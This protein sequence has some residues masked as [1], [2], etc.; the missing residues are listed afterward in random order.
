MARDESLRGRPRATATRRRALRAAAGAAAALI[1][2]PSTGRAATQ[3]PPKQCREDAQ[4]ILDT[5]LLA[6]RI[7]I[8]FYYTGLTTRAVV[9]DASTSPPSPGR[10][11]ARNTVY[12]QSILAEERE[13]TRLLHSAG[14]RTTAAS[15]YFPAATFTRLGYTSRSGLFLQ[16]FDLIETVLVGA[17]LAAIDNL[18]I[19][20]RTDLAVLAIRILEA[21]CKHRALGRALARDDPADNITLEVEPFACV[22]DA[23]TAL[24]PFL[25]GQGF[26]GGS[27]PPIPLPTRD[28]VARV[29]QSPPKRR[30]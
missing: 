13:H 1:A 18:G 21:E 28:Q 16:V 11:S 23:A 24:R 29:L 15:F 25:T 7:A 9:D 4:Q 10:N 26:R 12:L 3:P 19:L 27:T 17:Y 2:T 6:E 5:V 14:A 30:P 20:G 22:G 8:T